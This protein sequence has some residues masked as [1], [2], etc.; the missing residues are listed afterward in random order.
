LANI[1]QDGMV[2]QMEP[3]S[4]RIWGLGEPHSQIELSYD[5]LKVVSLVG[6]TLKIKIKPRLYKNTNLA[7][8]VWEAVLPPH[9]EGGPVEFQI[10]HVGKY[11][12]C[13][14]QC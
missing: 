7:D 1:Y 9:A 4:A 12:L 8:G 10:I 6:G 5:N 3:K 14:S 2:L 11:N 13:K